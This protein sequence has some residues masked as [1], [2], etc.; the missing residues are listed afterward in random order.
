MLANKEGDLHECLCAWS[1]FSPRVERSAGNEAG[2]KAD[3]AATNAR[4]AEIS[5]ERCIL[6]ATRDALPYMLCV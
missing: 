6:E 1:L 5:T 3:A 2:E 4:A